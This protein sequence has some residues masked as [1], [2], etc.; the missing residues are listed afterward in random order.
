MPIERLSIK[1]VKEAQPKTGGRLNTL[2]DGGG[3]ILL[4]RQGKHGPLK[5]WAF[6]Y[7]FR[8]NPERRMGLG[9]E[10]TYTL[11]EARE[12]GR[13]A[14]KLLKRGVDPLDEKNERMS[15]ARAQKANA[16]TFD[17]TAARY[18]KVHQSSWKNAAHR[19]QW[20]QSLHDYISPII[21][22]IEVG[23]ITVDDVLKV[24]LP[25]WSIMPE[26]AT[27][28]RQRIETVL[29]FAGRNGGNPAKWEGNLEYKLPKRDKARTVKKHTA[30]PYDDMPSFMTE[31]RAIDSDAARALELTILCATRRNETLG[32]I[33]SEFDL[34]KCT[35]TIPVER[36]KRAGEGEDG[37]HTIPL[38]DAAMA[39]LHGMGAEQ[40]GGRVFSRINKDAMLLLLKTL[41]PVT[42]HGMRAS[43]RSWA[44]A[45]TAIP[46]DVCEMALG[47]RVGNAAETAYQRS[48]LLA[49]RRVLMDAWAEFCAAR[50]EEDTPILA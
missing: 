22:D 34:K 36:L 50:N 18:V 31:L 15:T 29:D 27:R 40:G 12:L 43:F 2:N 16:A 3:L 33:W 46:R 47:H 21:G 48:S 32:A 28:I 8:G 49:K 20:D 19:R 1:A 9:P 5:H 4:V 14:R 13:E 44:G 23:S 10:H 38:S 26:S 39:V 6:R 7:S 37:S 17:E 25:I 42:L 30:L 45:E 24:L 41:R 35:W 11:E